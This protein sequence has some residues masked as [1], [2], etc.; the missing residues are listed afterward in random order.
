MAVPSQRGAPLERL[1]HAL[2]II[3]LTKRLVETH[4]EVLLRD[5]IHLEDGASELSGVELFLIRF[6]ALE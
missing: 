3:V 1:F 5:E 6:D 4:L 2:P